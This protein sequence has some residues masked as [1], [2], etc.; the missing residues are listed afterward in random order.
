[1]SQ[2]TSNT[3]KPITLTILPQSQILP[4][5]PVPIPNFNHVPIVPT[6]IPKSPVRNIEDLQ[7]KEIRRLEGQRQRNH[8]YYEKAKNYTKIGTLSSEKDKLL[9]LLLLCYPSLQNSDKYELERMV[10]E[11]LT[12][13]VSRFDI[14]SS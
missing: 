9:A 14:I 5:N 12:A 13:V 2:T 6:F 8:R 10:I 7:E 3:I 4:M 1:M 11:F